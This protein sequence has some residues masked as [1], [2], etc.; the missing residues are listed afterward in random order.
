MYICV[1]AELDC[2]VAKKQS[3]YMPLYMLTTRDIVIPMIDVVDLGNTEKYYV[4]QRNN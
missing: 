2:N 1:L 3:I 4:L